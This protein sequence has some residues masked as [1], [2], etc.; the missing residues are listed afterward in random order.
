MYRFKTREL[1]ELLENQR[2]NEVTA[3]RVLDVID[4]PA[5]LVPISIDHL[6]ETA[7]ISHLPE[8]IDRAAQDAEGDEFGARNVDDRFVME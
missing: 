2:A 7:P 8:S 1:D 4:P 6:P 5:I 3:R